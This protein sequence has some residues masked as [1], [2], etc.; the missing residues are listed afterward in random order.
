M[1]CY[2]FSAHVQNKPTYCDCP[3]AAVL[4]ALDIGYLKASGDKT[5]DVKTVCL[6]KMRTVFDIV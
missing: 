4:K 6:Q 1:I 3:C 5:G 2:M